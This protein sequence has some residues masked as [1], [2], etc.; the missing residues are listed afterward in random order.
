MNCEK[1]VI[2]AHGIQLEDLQVRKPSQEAK[3]GSQVRGGENKLMDS[4]TMTKGCQN[5][6]ISLRDR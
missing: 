2:E 3:S 1:S 6:V 4:S 5:S